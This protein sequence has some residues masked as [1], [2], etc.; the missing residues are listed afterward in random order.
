MD[1]SEFD[2]CLGKLDDSPEVIKLLKGL[3][4]TK[5]L[6]LASD[7]YMTLDLFDQGVMLSFVRA[8]P[9]SSHLMFTGATFY[10]DVE[11]Y[12]EFVGALPE[13]LKFSDTQKEVRAKLGKPTE[14]LDE[15]GIDNWRKPDRFVSISYRGAGTIANVLWSTPE[16]E[17]E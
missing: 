17:P 1:A 2:R 4:V 12:T 14:S 7:D 5:K 3:G 16:P 13:N 6:K 11:D 8:E 9:K 10:T 15:F